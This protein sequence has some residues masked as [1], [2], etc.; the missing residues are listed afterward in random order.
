MYSD[1]RQAGDYDTL[2][3]TA[4][5]ERSVAFGDTVANL[6]TATVFGI[7]RALDS[8]KSGNDHGGTRR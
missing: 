1:L 2:V 3:R 4:R 8:F 5:M 7:T 6:I